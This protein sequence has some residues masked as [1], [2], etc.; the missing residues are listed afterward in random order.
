M[1]NHV[2]PPAEFIA[3]PNIL[4]LSA[5]KRRCVKFSFHALSAHDK[6]RAILLI[7]ICGQKGYGNFY[8]KTV[9]WGKI[10]H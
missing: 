2:K 1:K 7:T 5:Q 10:C 9:L 4:C 3:P 8:V 6:K